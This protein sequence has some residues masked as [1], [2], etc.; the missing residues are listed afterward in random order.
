MFSKNILQRILILIITL[1]NSINCETILDQA[2]TTDNEVCKIVKQKLVCSKVTTLCP[3][4]ACD[5]YKEIT[6]DSNLNTLKANSFSNYE[7]KDQLTI[8]LNNLKR[9][10]RDAF[11]GLILNTNAQLNINILNLDFD[12]EKTSDQT[13]IKSNLIIETNALRDMLIASGAKLVIRIKNFDLVEF[14]GD[15]LLNQMKQSDQSQVIIQIETSNHVVFRSSLNKRDSNLNRLVLYYF[16][17]II[18]SMI[19]AFKQM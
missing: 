16:Y 10:E 11:N 14:K 5:Q 19:S 7:I 12:Q 17:Y 4:L 13:S 1:T 15:S 8:N 6:Y 2:L 9:I 3:T 18:G